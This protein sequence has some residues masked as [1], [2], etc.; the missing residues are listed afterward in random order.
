MLYPANGKG[1]DDAL[2]WKSQQVLVTVGALM[3]GGIL[4]RI[5]CPVSVLSSLSVGTFDATF[6]FNMEASAWFGLS[7]NTTFSFTLTVELSSVC[8]IKGTSAAKDI[9]SNGGASC[10][11]E[12]E[13]VSGKVCLQGVGVI[14]S[15]DERV[16]CDD[17]SVLR[18]FP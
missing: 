15:A 2:A 18:A 7:A 6:S 11:L 4:D 1:V 13:A 10:N 8:V 16:L 14:W 9:E 3:T 17:K 12:G 5:R